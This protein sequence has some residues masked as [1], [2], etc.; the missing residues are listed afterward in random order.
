MLSAD[1]HIIGPMTFDVKKVMETSH[2]I[3][4]FPDLAN[5]PL[6]LDVIN[7]A[8]INF[9]GG[10]GPAPQKDLVDLADQTN[11][12]SSS[13]TPSGPPAIGHAAANLGRHRRSRHRFRTSS[14][15]ERRFKPI[16]RSPQTASRTTGRFIRD[17][18]STGRFQ[19]GHS[20]RRRLSIRRAASIARSPIR[21]RSLSSRRFPWRAIRLINTTGGETSLGLIGVNSVTSGSG[22]VLTFSGIEG[23]LNCDAG[24]ADQSGL[25][26]FV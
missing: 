5:L 9:A 12:A 20:V 8:N 23:L 15:Q 26:H 24:G 6:I 10:P 11:N 19:P 4:D 13:P 18:G 21:A 14:I 16:R 22:G 1:G 2:L 25:R 17:R 3:V 7:A